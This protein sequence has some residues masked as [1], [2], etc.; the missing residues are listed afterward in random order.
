MSTNLAKLV[1]G[2]R[3][4]ITAVAASGAMKRRLMD[5]GVLPGEEVVVQKVAPL[6]DPIEVRV[7]SYRLSLRKSEAEG[8]DVEV[9]P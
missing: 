2:V 4:R 7:R 9:T 6:G 5:M 8:I 3:A 1:P